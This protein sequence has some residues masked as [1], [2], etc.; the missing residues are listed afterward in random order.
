MSSADKL[1][2]AANAAEGERDVEQLKTNGSTGR[3]RRDGPE[4]T[5]AE[6]LASGG[7]GRS[8]RMGGLKGQRQQVLTT[9]LYILIM[10]GSRDPRQENHFLLGCHIP[11][12]I[13]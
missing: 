13:H 8:A 5:A 3:V 12:S 1:A 7:K 2:G 11:Q 9:C 10:K 4:R 6:T